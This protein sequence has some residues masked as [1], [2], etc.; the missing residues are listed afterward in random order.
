MSSL[1]VGCGPRRN[2]LDRGLRSIPPSR[3]E[4]HPG[5]DLGISGV[6]PAYEV[7]FVGGQEFN[8]SFGGLQSAFD[9]IVYAR[10]L[11]DPPGAPLSPVEGS[12]GGGAVNVVI[13]EVIKVRCGY[14]G[15]LNLESDAKCL[16][17][18]AKLG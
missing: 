3:L 4:K 9:E 6:I 14:C 13:R 1:S 8:C 10:S 16:S 2:R 7:I 18:G 5:E 11:L 15:V 17:C 12:E